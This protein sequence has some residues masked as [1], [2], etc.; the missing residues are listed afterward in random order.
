MP[1][2]LPKCCCSRCRCCSCRP[3]LRHA[4]SALATTIPFFTPVRAAGVWC[5]LHTTPAGGNLQGCRLPCCQAPR[6]VHGPPCRGHAGPGVS[7]AM[8][9]CRHTQR[10]PAAAAAAEG[11]LCS[12]MKVSFSLSGQCMKQW[13]GTICWRQAVSAMAIHPPLPAL[14]TCHDSQASACSRGVVPSAHLL[15]GK[16]SN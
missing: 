4:W 14:G 11:H 3:Q 5:H 2:T 10:A 15:L 13:C 12:G 1:R 7:S 8:V 9:A 6:S 16:R